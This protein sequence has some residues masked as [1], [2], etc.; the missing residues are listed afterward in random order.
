[1]PCNTYGPNDNYNLNSSHFL[2]ALIKKIFLA[3]K[4]NKK[5][6]EIWGNGRSKREVI[7]VDDLANA[8][9]YFSF[10]KINVNIL[11]IGTE[12]EM[13]IEDYAKL[14]MNKLNIK[15]KIN[16]VNRNLNGTPRKILDCSLA[17]RFGWKS[18]Y[19]LDEGLQ[20]TI[21]DFIKN[22]NKYK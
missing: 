22:F 21:S 2:P 3:K 7:F 1:M 19:S 20:I 6:I 11:N 9:I 18:L 15:L 4:N 8:I 13:T 10:K 14:I 12:K 16:Y 5:N 17:R